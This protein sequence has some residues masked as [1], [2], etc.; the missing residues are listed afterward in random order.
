M[1]KTP[2]YDYLIVG[3]GLFGAVCAY[4]L[5]QQGKKVLVID[6]RDHIAGNC[7]TKNIDG[8][9]VHQYGAHIFHTSDQAVWQFVQKFAKFNNFINSVVAKYGRESYHLPFNMHTFTELWPDVKTAKQA[10]QHIA[11]EQINVEQPKN[12]EEQAIKLVGRTIYQKL[13]KG[14]TEKQWG[15]PCK[16]LPPEII[17]RIPVRFTFDNNYF[18]DTYQGIPIGGYTKLIA[19]MLTGV[20]VRLKTDYFKHR[21]KLNQ[22]AEHIIYTGPIDQFYDYRFG[23]L[24][25]RSLKF[26]SRRFNMPDYQGNAVLNYTATTPKYTRTIEHKHFDSSQKTAHTIVTY[27]YPALWSA[28]KEPY[29]VIND[30][31]NNTLAERYRNL[32]NREEKVIFGGR[33]ADYR[34]YD[35]DDVIKKALEIKLP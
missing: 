27:E 28:G 22:L 10:K 12:L 19:K 14:Y 2:K 31:H 20:E 6:K 25:Y 5:H 21:T 9:E 32:A 17:Q 13:I 3:A 34:Y 30:Q 8:I 16:N 26:R 18:N 33:L 15:R 4:R 7:Y 11:A 35:M 23:Q 24:E 1:A 29:Y